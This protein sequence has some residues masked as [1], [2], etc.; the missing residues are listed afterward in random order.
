LSLDLPRGRG[1]S[2]GGDLDIDDKG[3]K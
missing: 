2:I 3:S 1:K